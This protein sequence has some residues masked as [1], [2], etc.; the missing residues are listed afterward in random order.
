MTHSGF[1]PLQ[2]AVE[3]T[4]DQLGL[5]VGL[6]TVVIHRIWSK[7]VGEEVARRSQPSL[8][9]NGRLQ[10]TVGDAVWLQ[11]LT[12]LK[13]R[14]LASLESHVGAGVVRDIFFILRTPSVPTARPEPIS[15]RRVH[16]PLSEIQGRVQD[17][18]R[19]VQDQECRE[20]LARILRKA[21][22]AE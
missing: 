10:V 15:R 22:E 4:L 17:I 1:T 9:K 11:Q 14:I 6:A 19:P 13:P 5:G 21:C 2:E 12:M 16:P 3:T 20:V 18:L 8:L 7:V